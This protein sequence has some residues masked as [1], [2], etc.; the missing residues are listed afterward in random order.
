M[1][2]KNFLIQTVVLLL[3]VISFTSCKETSPTTG[4]AYN[5]AKNGGFEVYPFQEQATGPGLVL[6][7]GGTFTFGRM[8]Q[9]VMYEWNNTPRRVTI[10]SFYMDETEIS[11]LDYLEYLYWLERVF[12]PADLKV[13]Y[14]NAL[15]DENV[16]R[17]KLTYA[18]TQ[19]EYYFRYPAYRNYPVVGVSWLQVTNYAAWR[20]DRVNEKILVD[21]GLIEWS[22]EP[23]PEGYFNT[24]AYLTY[25]SYEAES[26]KRLQYITTGE[27]RNA[28]MEDGILLPK[29]RL[30]TEA[31]WEYAA[32]GLIGNTLNERVLER[33]LYPWNGHYTRTDEKKYYGDFVANTR[34]GRG[35][36]MGV[37]G[38]LND[39][40]YMPAPVNSYWPNDYGLYNMGGN[41]AEWVMDVY[42]QS[43]HDDLYE[44]SPFRGN[45]YETKKLLEDGTVE[46]RDSIGRVPM[47]PV[48][49]FKNDRRRNYRQA[50][51][52]NFLD[53]DWA[54]LNDV[55][56][57]KNSSSNSTDAMYPKDIDGNYSLVGDHARVYKG[58]SWVD[59][60][61]YAGPGQRRYLDEDESTKYI[62]FRCAMA[63]LGAP[64]SSKKK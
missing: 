57:W 12:V 36:F 52:I 17:E 13:V 31:E 26:D 37:A 42:R 46:E 4:W 35:D 54:S 34:R 43:S 19:V 9:D 27:Y 53:G 61:Y 10:P 20:T 16:W 18:E 45:Y 7:E 44:L 38:Y 41:V 51:N 23:S 40:A 14:D 60:Q 11:N 29:Y 8:E 62:G 33:K 24:D 63:R 55:D 39:A 59:I 58:G 47:V 56:A 21:E 64:T 49:D 15:P 6:I 2:T 25:E 3:C 22:P 50:D 48:S 28:R 30:P 5:D 32:Y 1:K